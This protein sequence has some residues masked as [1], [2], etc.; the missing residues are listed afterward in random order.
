VAGWAEEAQ[1]RAFLWGARELLAE[2][3]RP[4][5]KREYRLHHE[6]IRELIARVLGDAVLRGHHAAL[7]A[8]IA[9]WPVTADATTRRYALRHGL[10]HRAEAGDWA[11]AWRL[12]ADA[13]F[14]EAQCRELGV[15]G[16]EADVVRTAERCR[17]SGDD[18]LHRRF[19]DLARALARES[20]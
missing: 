6:S 7:A 8:R 11:G 5:G 10:T 17:A 18:A 20:R 16:A 19:D 3:W 1:R 2:T 14:V 9:G 13:S 4:D 15:H 12:A